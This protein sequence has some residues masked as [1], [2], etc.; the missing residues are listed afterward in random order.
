MALDNVGCCGACGVVC[1]PKTPKFF[2][3]S[4]QTLASPDHPV[5]Q[6]GFPVGLPVTEHPT[7]E[8][9]S[10]VPG[11]AGFFSIGI[12]SISFILFSLVAHGFWLLNNIP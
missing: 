1:F 2:Q 5:N 3:P 9:R 8:P 12:Y 10:M 6:H 7:V 4:F 11:Q